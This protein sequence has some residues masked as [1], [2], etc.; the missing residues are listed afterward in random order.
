[1]GDWVFLRLQPYKQ[2]SVAYRVAHKLSP[3]FFRPFQ[4]LERIGEVV[5]KLDL[6]AGSAIHP[7]FHVSC[8]MTKLG[9]HNVSVSLLPSVNSQ[10]F[11]TLEPVVVLQTRSH[12]L[13]NRTSTQLLI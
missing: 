8:L 13:Q 1:M 10:G 7:V 11:L 9:K 2:Q 5:Y 4:I 6:H 12:K 3:K